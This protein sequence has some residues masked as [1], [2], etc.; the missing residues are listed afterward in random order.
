[1]MLKRI[2]ISLVIFLSAFAGL[3]LAENPQGEISTEKR[4]LIR[5]LILITD[6][7]KLGSE[8][9]D[10][11][12]K[13]VEAQYPDILSQILS[14]NLDF[15]TPEA[16]QKF[17]AQARESFDRFARKFRERYQ[18]KINPA[19]VIEEISYPLYD[20]YFNEQELRD[21]IAFY[22]TPTGEKTLKVMPLLLQESME[23]S[24]RLVGP[25]LNGLVTELLDE[26]KAALEA[27]EKTVAPAAPASPA[28]ADAPEPPQPEK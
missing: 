5:E 7:N 8:F 14:K 1:M 12:L 13:N 16:K 4:A 27:Q 9:V 15:A 11:M 21:L 17:E 3:Y 25:K 22:R 19:G 26:E 23:M 10:A 20:K 28:K 2:A 24:G 18:D 6:A